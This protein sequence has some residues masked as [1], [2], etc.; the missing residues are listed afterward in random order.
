MAWP[1][2]A[3][4]VPTGSLE[5]FYTLAVLLEWSEIRMPGI[6]T[7]FAPMFRLLAKQ[8]RCMGVDR[9]LEAR[10]SW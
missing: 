5:T 2:I 9:D 8:G 3:W 4:F 1:T 10:Y 6:F 7:V